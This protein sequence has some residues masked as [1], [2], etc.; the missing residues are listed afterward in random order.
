MSSEEI[1]RLVE[2]CDSNQVVLI[3]RV[4]HIL[5]DKGYP[6]Y[7]LRLNYHF[8]YSA[9]P[10]PLLVE[11]LKYIYHNKFSDVRLIIPILKG[12]TKVIIC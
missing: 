3:I 8:L 11:K 1:L 6:D 5:T 12:L 2:N 9:L 10:S 4:I 7:K